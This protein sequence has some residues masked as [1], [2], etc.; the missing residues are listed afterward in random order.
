MCCPWPSSTCQDAVVHFIHLSWFT[1]TYK[2]G[3]GGCMYICI[4]YILTW[5]STSR[6]SLGRC[7]AHSWS[8]PCAC[9][10]QV[11]VTASWE[12]NSHPVNGERVRQ[13]SRAEWRQQ[14]SSRTPH[15]PQ[16]LSHN[17]ADTALLHRPHPN[18]SCKWQQNLP[19]P[20]LVLHQNLTASWNQCW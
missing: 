20:A 11:F 6:C 1:C 3:S 16:T 12:R 5:F 10:V 7:G 17:Q 9:D 18:L 2:P 15:K 8:C 19:L 13:E 4:M 14:I